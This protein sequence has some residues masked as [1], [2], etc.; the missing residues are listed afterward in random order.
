MIRVNFLR[1]NFS[2][3]GR[4]FK[5]IF[6]CMTAQNANVALGWGPASRNERGQKIAHKGCHKN[7]TTDLL[8]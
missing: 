2:R 8:T 5:L 1:K 6:G 4:P 3:C 7:S